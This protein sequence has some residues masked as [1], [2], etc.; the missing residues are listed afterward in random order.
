[1]S[2]YADKVAALLRK[3]DSTDS[4][5][6]RDALIS[7]AQQLMSKYGIDQALIDAANGKV[8]SDEIELRKIVTAGLFHEVKVDL[9]FGIAR[10][11][12]CKTVYRSSGQ[13]GDTRTVGEKTYKDWHEVDIVGYRSDLDAVDFLYAN[14]SLQCSSAL[15]AWHKANKQEWW[16]KHQDH[17]ERR[18][19]IR[20]FAQEVTHRL[21]LAR[22]AAEKE[23]A[24]EQAARNNTT[25]EEGAKGVA[26]ALRSRADNVSDWY[27]NHYGSSLRTVTR[28][29]SSG[30]AGAH[31]A[32]RSA[33]RTANIGGASL[34][35]QQRGLNA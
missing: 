15:A 26:L 16:S 29:Y 5:H 6:E 18:T 22:L 35:G 9:V 19:F 14:L 11:N 24:A 17:K 28:R 8:R 30:S 10:A 12:R 1:M 13:W 23:A 3:A 34:G 20:A 2:D 32:G 4:E 7:K 25:E 33:G 21:N 27:D 31:E